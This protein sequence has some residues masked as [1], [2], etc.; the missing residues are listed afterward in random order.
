M[1]F[2]SL[3]YHP[4]YIAQIKIETCL[5]PAERIE[6]SSAVLE[7]AVLPLYKAGKKSEPAT[8][9]PAQKGNH[10]DNVSLNLFQLLTILL[11]PGKIPL[12]GNVFI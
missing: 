2:M 9:R 1:L 10:Y 6:L 4:Q 7:T 8:N 5:A 11:Y 12:D 3:L